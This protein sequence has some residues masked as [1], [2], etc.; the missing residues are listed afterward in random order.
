MAAYTPGTDTNTA[1]RTEKFKT[2]SRFNDYW[3]NGWHSYLIATAATT[4]VEFRGLSRSDALAM[5]DSAVYNY[6]DMHGV[7]F[8]GSGVGAAWT[9][10]PDCEGTECKAVA[11]RINEADMWR[12]VVTHVSTTV[13]HNGGWSKTTF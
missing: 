11:R 7:R 8:T 3:F 1:F 13:T 5:A 4:V 9:S 10:A 6:K 12:V 2:V